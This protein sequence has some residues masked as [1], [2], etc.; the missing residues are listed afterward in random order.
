MKK[1]H[2]VVMDEE[3]SQELKIVAI[4]MGISMSDL[5][6]KACVEY[7][8]WRNEL[9]EHGLIFEDTRDVKAALD[10]KSALNANYGTAS[11]Q[12]VDTDNPEGL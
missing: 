9:I 7:L 6:S 12:Y 3:L 1:Q 5:I 8:R 11:Q 2:C 4:K 10:V